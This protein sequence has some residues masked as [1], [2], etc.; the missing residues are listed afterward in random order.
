M[1]DIGGALS[2]YIFSPSNGFYGD[3]WASLMHKE[4]GLQNEPKIIPTPC[5]DE[6]HVRSSCGQVSNVIQT[7][8]DL[9]QWTHKEYD[10]GF[11]ANGV[12]NVESLKRKLLYDASP[13]VPLVFTLPLFIKSLCF[14]AGDVP[15]VEN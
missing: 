11:T 1:S 12:S 14:L 15:V 5:E 13:K 3:L 4:M 6:L 9:E 8:G 10:E 7:M 2:Y